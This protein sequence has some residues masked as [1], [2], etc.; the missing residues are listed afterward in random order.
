M[1]VSRN[2]S[3]TTLRRPDLS[4]LLEPKSPAIVPTLDGLFKATVATNRDLIFC[5]PAIIEEW[6]RNFEYFEWLTTRTGVLFDSGPLNKVVG[7]SMTAQGVNIFILYG[8][9]SFCKPS[10]INTNIDAYTTSDLFTSHPTKTGYWRVHGRTNDQT[11]H[12]TGEKTNLGPLDQLNNAEIILNQDSHVI[13]SV[14]FGRG[15]FQAGIIVDPKPTFKLGPADQAKLAEYRNKIWPTVQK[16][17]AYAPQYSRLFKEPSKPFQYTAKT[18][19]RR[20][21]IINEYNKEIEALFTTIEAT[22]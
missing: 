6:S 10:V 20:Q 3:P 13:A 5:V 8:S 1:P 9:N 2:G 18:T 21:P 12:N 16:M 17:N 19:A 15:R 22:A 11:M 4:W 7:D 14:M